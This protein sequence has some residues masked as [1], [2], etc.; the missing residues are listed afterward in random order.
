[1]CSL[2][3]C[4]ILFLRSSSSP[5]GKGLSS[6][7]LQNYLGSGVIVFNLHTKQLVFS[8]ILEVS[9]VSSCFLHNID[10]GRVKEEWTL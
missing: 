8:S 2:P 10:I 4:M 5:P 7:E 3:T 1:M 6:E 9:R